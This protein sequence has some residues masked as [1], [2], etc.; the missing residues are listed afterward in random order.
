M[1]LTSQPDTSEPG[2]A[3]PG[4]TPGH[5][6]SGPAAEPAAEP[7]SRPLAVFGGLCGARLREGGSCIELPVEGRSRC[8]RHGGA[9]PVGRRSP[10]FRSGRY[11]RY[12]V[13][14]V[15]EERERFERYRADPLGE[16]L[17]ARVAL[18][19]IQH[20]RAIAAGG[21]GAEE[22]RT[23][24]TL[25]RTYAQITLAQKKVVHIPDEATAR[26]LF[27]AIYGAVRTAVERRLPAVEAKELLRDVAREVQA[28]DWGK[29]GVRR[30]DPTAWPYGTPPPSA[31]R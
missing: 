6:S 12:P 18:A 22:G 28:M 25:L 16:P 31:R 5:D 14:R 3:G 21:S 4:P 26:M 7:A 8:F 30:N 2:S 23:A 19:M 15:E 10:H 29:I 9:T 13:A 24:A 11:S 1:A 27:G 17:G 20:D